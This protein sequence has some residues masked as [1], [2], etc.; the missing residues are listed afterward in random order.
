N[1]AGLGVERVDL[2]RDALDPLF[3]GADGVFHLAAQPGTRTSWGDEFDVY[4]E[5]N[6][7]ASRRVFEAAHRAGARVVFA[8]SSSIYGD[9]ERYP[10]PEETTP[11]PISPYGVTKLACE[12]LARAYA[13]S[14]GLDYVALRYFTV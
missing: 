5:R 10:T 2:A 11:M 12:H 13:L 1:A 6:L 4:L 7:V 14:G 8:S 9:A 3:A